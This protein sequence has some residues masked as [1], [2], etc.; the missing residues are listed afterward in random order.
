MATKPQQRSGV[1]GLGSDLDKKTNPFL[2]TND[3]FSFDGW[4]LSEAHSITKRAGYQKI[5]SVQLSEGTYGPATFTGLWEYVPSAGLV[6]KV[7]TSKYGL[8][9]YDTPNA[10]EWNSISLSNCAARTSFGN[11]YRDASILLDQMYIG[12]GV[13]GNI[14]F[15]ANNTSPAA[16]NMGMAQATIAPTTVTSSTSGGSMTNGVYKYTYTYKNAMGAESNPYWNSTTNDYYVVTVGG[17]STAYTT[18]QHTIGFTNST[19]LDP[20]VTTRVIY[21]STVNGG[22]PLKLVEQAIA[23]TSYADTY[24]DSQLTIAVNLTANGVPPVFSMIDIYKGVAFMAGDPNNK[25]RVWFSGNSKPYAVDSNDYRDLDPNDGDIVTGI[26]RFLTTI[27]AFKN[28]SIWNAIG[29][30]R[31]DFGFD[32]KVTAVGSVNNASIVDVPHTNIL[33][34]LSPNGKFYFYDGTQATPTAINIEPLLSTFD[35]SKF[36]EVV[37]CSVPSYNQCRWLF[38]NENKIV[39]YDYILEKWG[40]TSITNVPGNFCAPMR[41]ELSALRFCLAGTSGYVW[42]GDRSTTDDGS[43]ITCEVIDRGHPKADVNPENNKMFYH[44]FVWFK[45]TA[46]VTLNTSILKNDP[47]GT[48]IVPANYTID[49]SAPSGQAHIHFNATARRLY[50]KI[51]ESSSIGGLV[52]RGWALY[53]KDIGQHNAP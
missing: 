23:L 25:S 52:L 44:L 18:C 36:T 34:F 43:A 46:G 28:N 40:T 11:V 37:G 51:T 42:Y 4:Y 27:V 41:D 29:N 2:A 13:N 3:L 16:W 5:N 48:P 9:V 1:L 19:T 38:P 50:V 7:A 17:T 21:R 35:K 33:A 15:D 10:N 14:R 26:K 8:F 22:L 32:R 30:D 6:K 49:A 24:S 45:P 12:D 20:Q 53:Y 39:W 31:T 47:D